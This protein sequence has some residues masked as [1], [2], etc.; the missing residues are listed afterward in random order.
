MFIDEKAF[1]AFATTDWF[2]IVDVNVPGVLAKTS[3]VEV[4]ELPLISSFLE[5]FFGH[6]IKARH[7]ARSIGFGGKGLAGRVA[8]VTNAM[9][10]TITKQTGP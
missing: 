3:T 10:N 9:A 7:V 5:I 1:A 6:L 8:L 4:F 2:V